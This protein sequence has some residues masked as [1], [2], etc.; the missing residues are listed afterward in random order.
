MKKLMMA[1][2]ACVCALGAMAAT[3]ADYVQNGLVACWDGYENSGRYQHEA[4]STEWVDVVGGRVLTLTDGE[5]F[6]GCEVTL[7]ASE[8]YTKD[9]LFD[10]PGDVTIEVN[11]RPVSPTSPHN[12]VIVGIPNFAEL[13]WDARN[14]GM[15]IKRVDSAGA[16]QNH[17]ISYDSGY[18]SASAIANS[19]VSQ[20]YTALIGV[21]SSAVYVNGQSRAQTTGLDWTG[22]PRSSD[23]RVQVG[24]PSSGEVIRSIRIYNRKLSADEI[25]ANHAV[26]VK[27]FD[28]GDLSGWP[29]V[30]AI[31]EP[32]E[33][34]VAGLPVYGL[35]KKSVG[36]TAELNAPEG[37]VEVSDGVRAFCAGWKLYDGETGELVSESTDATRTRCTFTYEKSVRLVWQWTFRIAPA[38]TG[39]G[40][41]I[42]PSE[43]W[44]AEDQ[45]VIFTVTGTDHPVWTVGGVIQP[46]RGTSITVRVSP[47]LQISVGEDLALYVTPNGAGQKDGSSWEN[48]FAGLQSALTA[49][50]TAGVPATLKVLAGDYPLAAEVF[51]DGLAEQVVIR[52]GYTGVNDEIDVN[53]SVFYRASEGDMRLFR[54]ENSY[55]TF[56]NLAFTNG[57]FATASADGFA[58]HLTKCTTTMKNCAVRENGG[59][60]V[61]GTYRGTIYLS[62][63]SFAATDCD[64]SD[65]VF[66]TY[67]Y[68]SAVYGVGI[69]ATGVS[70][71]TLR[72]CTVDRNRTH[73][74]Y[75]PNQGLGVYVT[76]GGL[77]VSD[78]TFKGNYGRRAE[79]YAHGDAFG[80]AI[81]YGDGA[82][83]R[84][85]ITDSLFERNW[86]NDTGAPG[87]CLY[88]KTSGEASLTR[89]VFRD[90]GLRPTDDP[91]AG[92]G[93]EMDR[94]D[95]YFSGTAAGKHFGVTNCTFVG[96]AHQD[97]VKVGAGTV[98][99]YRC[100]FAGT[101]EGYGI[102]VLGGKAT[103]RD[104][105][106]WGNALGGVKLEGAGLAEVTYTDTQD[107]TEGIGNMTEDPLFAEGGWGH[108]Q[109]EAGYYTAGFTGGV[110]TVAAATSPMIDKGSAG[111][112]LGLEPQPNKHLPNLGG[113]AGTEVASMSKLGSA[114]V[115]RDDELKVFAY[116]VSPGDGVGMIR[117]EVASTGDG[118]NPTVSV[119]WGPADGGTSA[120]GDW[121]YCTE[122]GTFAPWELF[123]AEM[124]NIAGKA[125]CRLV[126][127]NEKGVA[128]SDPAIEFAS[129]AR[130]TFAAADVIRV[131]RTTAY[132]KT[133]I[134]DNGG[135][136]TKI[137][138]LV[139]PS[140]G[141][142]ADAQILDFNDGFVAEVGK[143]YA[144]T[145]PGLTADV[146]YNFL[147]KA[148]N[149]SGTTT[150]NVVKTTHTTDA[151]TY[152]VSPT[153]A[154]DKDG[155][156]ESS[157]FG[158]LQEAANAATE[159]GDVVYLTAGEYT[160]CQT[161]VPEDLSYVVVSGA[162]GLTV[163]GDPAGG[164]VFTLGVEQKRLL[165]VTDSTATFNDITFRGGRL[166]IGGSYGHG[167][168]GE[169]SALVFNRCTFDNNG[170]TS[171]TGNG[172][173]GGGLAANGGSVK[174]N[175]CAFTKNPIVYNGG[176]QLGAG[177]WTKNVALEAKG[178]LFATNYVHVQ[179]YGSWGGAIYANGG[180]ALI[181][182]C[183]FNGNYVMHDRGYDAQMSRPANGG[184]IYFDA[185]PSATV[186]DSTFD[187]NYANNLRS[188]ES[189]YHR[190]YSGGTIYLAGAAGVATIERCK[191]LRGGRWGGSP[192][193][194][195]VKNDNGS[196][197]IAA[198][199]AAVVNCLVTGM[200]SNAFEVAG[201][202]MAI[203]NVT[204]VGGDREP[205]LQKGGTVEVVNS[206]FWDNVSETGVSFD[207]AG[208]TTVVSHSDVTGG[209]EGEGNLDADPRFRMKS[210]NGASPYCLRGSSPCVNAGIKGS[211]T[212]DD[213]DCDSNPR[214]VGG[215]PD[216]GAFE[217]V[218][219]GLLLMVK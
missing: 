86:L 155:A 172:H 217:T 105:I 138:L 1:V 15:S 147:F 200:H 142:E 130:P 68:G 157:A 10:A 59:S 192:T 213:L 149:A 11:G 65:N 162:K 34:A 32:Q 56:E 92:T 47:G 95:V 121:A 76:D 62:G 29:G 177:I 145:V 144:I 211:W 35:T 66:D 167:V 78:C 153:G 72:N 122:I 184:A 150:T 119:V 164:T 195:N 89:C 140:A 194:A 219:N 170:V 98:D 215:V 189:V 187:G 88:I 12:M 165:H 70:L 198:G 64:I 125:Y 182:N 210:K 193:D 81:F 14:G 61:W 188:V 73:V 146:E 100:T 115:V 50:K 158:S 104:S 40:L 113:Y 75:V 132:A 166:N 44:I 30:F 169:N 199:T 202:T 60:L 25:A 49:A 37:V 212:A 51:I 27:R 99:F 41:S 16:T 171:G 190:D 160:V 159:P 201:G 108:L 133:A 80:G 174:L 176:S 186:V 114:P 181:T 175:D 58:L 4:S 57:C 209:F 163:N 131:Q 67:I 55:L 106:I 101:A 148:V 208:G 8:H 136:D 102:R 87:G 79:N 107:A 124:T 183:V 141:T 134:S 36:E 120:K 69:F 63:G 127:E 152:Y 191:I 111:G 137:S 151:R 53:R 38:V 24:S 18:S 6:D 173:Y 123:A 5:S 109:S 129:A 26:D 185:V 218:V 48:A 91:M 23:F 118:A 128:F 83:Y 20:T 112:D 110:W 143:E 139:Y 21:N 33:Y 90:N 84:L 116:D 46:E 45:D 179:H 85:E 161:K 156:S 3:T 117:G 31:G 28:E 203:T 205:V 216:M 54:A 204:V 126:V 52:G 2:C 206:I 97:A 7:V 9:A 71:V 96:T 103:V 77:Q 135:A 93:S 17:Y 94:G 74:K 19:G 154:G 207:I 82:S 168:Y 178:C 39:D 197:C 180:S 22:N 196:I 43:L 214:V 42:S 13:S